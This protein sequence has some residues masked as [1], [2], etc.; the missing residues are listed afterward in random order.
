MPKQILE[1][2]EF[3]S[4][5]LQGTSASSRLAACHIHFQI[6][7]PQRNSLFASPASEEG[8]NARQKLRE[9]KGFNQVIVTTLVE[10]PHTIFDCI[11]SGQDE[12]RRLQSTFSQCGQHLQTITSRKHQIQNDEVEL[13]CINKKES[14]LSGRCNDNFIFRAF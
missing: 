4:R 6:G 1:E 8:S 14:F 13:L 2:L 5:Q 10:S 9:G 11:S 3:P 12:N 7:K